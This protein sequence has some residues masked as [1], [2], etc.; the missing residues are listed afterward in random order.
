[1]NASDYWTYRAH[2]RFHDQLVST[3]WRRPSLSDVLV[4]CTSIY[5]GM[6]RMQSV[7]V[8]LCM[9]RCQ[10][11]MWNTMLALVPLYHAWILG[12]HMPSHDTLAPA[13]T[14][15][16][17]RPNVVARA[18]AVPGAPRNRASTTDADTAFALV[19][20]S[21]SIHGANWET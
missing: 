1:M 11:V 12:A 3:D 20:R 17:T 9:V 18:K 14:L 2:N 4:F 6:W 19:E 10:T 7:R 21:R 15:R 8:R 16:Y 5:A 13:P